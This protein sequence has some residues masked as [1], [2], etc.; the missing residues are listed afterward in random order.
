MTDWAPVMEAVHWNGDG[1]VPVITQEARTGQ[2]LM[3]AW[4]NAESLA[5]TLRDGYATYWSRSRNRLWRKGETSGH[6]QKVVDLRLDSDGDTILLQVNQEGPACH[7]GEPT[8]FFQG[9]PG[10]AGWRREDPPPASVLQRLAATIHARR[11]ADP[12][13]SY[14]A[15]LLHGGQDRIL[16]KVGEE[17]TEFLIAVKNGEPDAI[18]AEAADLLF[19]LLVALEERNL[20]VDQVL[21]ELARRQG[22]GGLAEKAARGK[23]TDVKAE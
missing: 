11:G 9:H 4:M 22:I 6:L 16:K 2:V 19:H 12:G 7:T 18:T 23:S 10:E 3:L 20:P 1:L 5:A 15:Q 21:H 14:V 17:A 13:Q 8:C